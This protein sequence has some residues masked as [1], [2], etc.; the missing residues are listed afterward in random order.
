MVKDI[1]NAAFYVTKLRGHPVGRRVRLPGFVFENRAVVSLDCKGPYRP[2]A[3]RQR[4]A[5]FP[6][7]RTNKNVNG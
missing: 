6:V 1:T 5:N 2:N 7:L 4:D 3:I